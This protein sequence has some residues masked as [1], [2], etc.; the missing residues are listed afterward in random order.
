MN[1]ISLIGR[2]TRDPEMREA[3]GKFV[4]NFTIAVDREFKRDEADFVRIVVWERQAEN[5]EKYIGKGSLV[6]VVGRLQTRNY[7]DKEGNKR[8]M[9]EVV[10][11]NVEFLDKRKQEEENDEIPF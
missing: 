9:T 8:T 1:N 5:C 6:G 2:L 10:A 7:E 3:G 4:A 11:R